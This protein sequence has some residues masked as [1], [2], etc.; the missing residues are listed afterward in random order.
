MGREGGEGA[1]KGKA[2]GCQGCI[3]FQMKGKWVEKEEKGWG[4]ENG[5][6]RVY[7]F[8]SYYEVF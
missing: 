3:F 7:F 5:C 1:G 6:H 4:R 2:T 8:F